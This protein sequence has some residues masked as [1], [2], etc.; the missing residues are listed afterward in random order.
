MQVA[1]S[2]SKRRK[3]DLDPA[4]RHIYPRPPPPVPK[5]EAAPGPGQ[6]ALAAP[7]WCGGAGAVAEPAPGAGQVVVPG[8]GAL[9]E[10]QPLP[11]PQPPLPGGLLPRGAPGLPVKVVPGHLQAAAAAARVHGPHS[12]AARPF[13]IKFIKSVLKAPPPLGVP[14]Q[15]QGRAA[16]TGTKLAAHKW[17]AGKLKYTIAL[18]QWPEG[19]LKDVM[20]WGQNW[21]GKDVRTI[22]ISDETEEAEV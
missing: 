17:P 2:A 19:V 21:N 13:R 18:K 12:G 20:P 11:P 4:P 10:A 1:S 9:L 14:G 15:R 7:W 22:D 3:L 16:T 5:V 6:S 8:V